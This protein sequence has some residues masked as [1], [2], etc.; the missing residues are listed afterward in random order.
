MSDDREH[1]SPV[2]KLCTGSLSEDDA[3]L[4]LGEVY[5]LREWFLYPENSTPRTAKMVGHFTQPWDPTQTQVAECYAHAQQI[6]RE[7]PIPKGLDAEEVSFVIRKFVQDWIAEELLDHPDIDF[8]TTRAYIAIPGSSSFER[9]WRS[10]DWLLE[11]PFS[12][13]HNLQ[14]PHAFLA[15]LKKHKT[16][17]TIRVVGKPRPHAVGHPKCTCGI[18]AYHSRDTIQM[19]SP[20]ASP[21]S[22]IVL[23]MI[24]GY[25]YVTVG[26]K[27]FR[28]EKVD[29]VALTLPQRS[30]LEPLVIGQL[31]NSWRKANITI[32]P[33][34]PALLSFADRGGYLLKQEDLN[35]EG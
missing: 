33:D 17:V 9:S 11:D 12:S 21:P 30:N 6:K 4:T 10:V 15:S 16:Q 3:A 1:L 34:L 32:L 18:Y 25:G 24:K 35:L 22:G 2:Q 13:V 26:T 20:D 23:G 8:A 14:I 29:V 27:G 28:A 31:I 19:S 5:G 7:I